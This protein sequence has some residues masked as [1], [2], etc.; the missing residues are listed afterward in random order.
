MA[1]N[2]KIVLV[3]AASNG[4]SDLFHAIDVATSHVTTG[5]G[6]GEVS[7]S[8]GGGEFSAE[9]SF[10]G[11]FQN[12]GVVY[13]A[14]SGD[15]GGVNIYP[16]TSPYVVS[17]GGTTIHRSSSGTFLSETGWSGSGGGPSK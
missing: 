4:F 17:S 11:H 10:D 12:L 15:T 9:S 14:A 6:R 8:W 16:S 1:P 3:E 5:G 7:M 13:F 2:A